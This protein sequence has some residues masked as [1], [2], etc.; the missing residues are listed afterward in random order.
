[1]G[2]CGL[3]PKL[4]TSVFILFFW[5]EGAAEGVEWVFMGKEGA[6][7]GDSM[8]GCFTLVES[9][10]LLLLIFCVLPANCVYSLFVWMHF[11]NCFISNCI[12]ALSWDKKRLIVISGF[13]CINKCSFLIIIFSFSSFFREKRDKC[14]LLLSLAEK[15]IY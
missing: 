8:G 6:S 3:T 10:W 5:G 12:C 2:L 15:L 1:M 4:I 14:S 7:M 13:A 11:S 9:L